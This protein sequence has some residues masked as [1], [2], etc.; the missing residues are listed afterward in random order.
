MLNIH[1]SLPISGGHYS[2][3][4]LTSLAPRLEGLFIDMLLIVLYK[5][6]IRPGAA[7]VSKP[8]KNFTFCP[9][10]TYDFIGRRGTYCSKRGKTQN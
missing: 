6:L 7:A 2:V 4:L 5:S 8:M 10:A 3:S 1:S 9:N